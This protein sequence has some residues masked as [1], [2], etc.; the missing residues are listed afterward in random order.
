MQLRTD[1]GLVGLNMTD[2][3]KA[4]GMENA[5]RKARAFHREVPSIAKDI[6]DDR[7]SIFM[8]GATGNPVK[9]LAVWN[10][11]LKEWTMLCNDIV[12]ENGGAA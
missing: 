3:S 6:T 11:H 7:I 4:V 2:F 12:W 10:R 8:V 9:A 1:N 5:T